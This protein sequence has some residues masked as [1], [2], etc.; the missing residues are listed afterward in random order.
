MDK[1]KALLMATQDKNIKAF[2]DGFKEVFLEKFEE[3]C[4]SL[5]EDV[6]KT[7]SRFSVTEKKYKEEDDND[8]DNTDDEAFEETDFDEDEKKEILSEVR[9]ND[10]FASASKS[11]RLEM[12]KKMG[13]KM[14]LDRLKKMNKD[15]KVTE[16]AERYILRNKLGVYLDAFTG[17]LSA[18]LKYFKS[19]WQT[20][21]C[22]VEN[23]AGEI[24][25]TFRK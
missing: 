21:N 3:K 8:E 1:F 7:M 19:Q 23:E 14:K 9:K 18:A 16:M 6:N 22:S 2:Q 4:L 15:E 20:A 11:D 5:E 24:V 25:K 17:S 10:K 12:I 13:E